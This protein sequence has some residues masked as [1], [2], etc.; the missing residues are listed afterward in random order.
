MSEKR[1]VLVY[2]EDILE[3]IGRIEKNAENLSREDF[4]RNIEKQ[5]AVVHRLEI[6]GEAAKNVPQE[7]RDK[8][9][10]IPWRE[11]ARTRDKITHHYFEIDI[12]QIWNI[13]QK[14]LQPLK[15]QIKAILQELDNYLFEK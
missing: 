4:S 11:I 10:K 12:E 7:F 2:L 9:P 13:I 14:D 1:D 8:Y 6:I 5:D 3:S 15:K